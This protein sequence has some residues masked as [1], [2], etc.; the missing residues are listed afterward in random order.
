MSAE[1]VTAT[2]PRPVR[3]AWTS[4]QMRDVTFVHWAVAPDVVRPLLPAGTEPD[5]FD[6]T[7]YVGL[8]ALRVAASPLSLPPMPYVGSFP[9]T[10]VRLYTVDDAGR[11]G[12][13]FLS[14]DA[15]RLVPGLVGRAVGLPYRWS[16]MHVHRRGSVMTYVCVRRRSDVA[17]RLVVRV[18]HP[19]A[20][21]GPLALFLTARWG[22]H[23]DAG[24]RRRYLAVEHE[25]WPLYDA[26]LVELQDGLVAAGLRDVRLDAPC[27][28]LWSPGV[29]SRFGQG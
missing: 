4:V 9:Q 20:S 25:P 26:G 11:R 24:G 12:V 28:V 18:G 3:H 2:A 23:L 1:P 22:M 21:P 5:L 10:N 8:V 6:G 29:D 27:S 13:T 19:T 7:A 16:S 17:S 14:M 15:A